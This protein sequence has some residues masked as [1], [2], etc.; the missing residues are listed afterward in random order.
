MLDNTNEGDIVFDPCA[1][2]GVT[3]QVAIENN[4]QYIC[5]ELDKEIY[6]KSIEYL[7]KHY[8]KES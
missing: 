6:D 5:C 1:G 2:S 4:R 7:N 8:I 3:A